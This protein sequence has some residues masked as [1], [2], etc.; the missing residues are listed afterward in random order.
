V[1]T[2]KVT[3]RAEAMQCLWALQEAACSSCRDMLTR[4]AGSSVDLPALVKLTALLDVPRVALQR[5]AAREHKHS[6]QLQSEA[7]KRLQVRFHTL[8][9][10]N[11]ELQDLHVLLSLLHCCQC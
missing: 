7:E 6:A 1:Q 2:A 9:V 10:W 4:V 5:K 11:L 8:L 3:K